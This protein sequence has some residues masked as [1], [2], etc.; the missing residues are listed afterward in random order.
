MAI[1]SVKTVQIG[2]QEA[3]KSLADLR[4]QITDCKNELFEL[5]EGSEEYNDKLQ[6]LGYAQQELTSFMQATRQGCTALEGSYNAL[7]YQLGLLKQ[8]WKSTNDEARRA[9][10]T[11]QI[12][13]I[14]DKL[15][16]MDASVGVFSRN[17]GNYTGSMVDAFNKVGINIGNINPLFANLA[18]GMVE[19]GAKGAKGLS[20]LSAGAKGLGAALKSLAANPI[21]AIIMAIVLAVKA[22]KA[23]FDAVK[24]SVARNEEA[25][26]N[27]AKAA[28]P[29]KAIIQGITNVF[30]EF[31]E[32][33]S[34]VAAGIGSA[35]SAIAKFFKGDSY[36]NSLVGKM[37]EIAELEDTI[38]E[39]HRNNMVENARL[40]MEA[41]EAREKA[42]NKEQY[43]NE[44]RLAFAKEYAE[45]QQEIAANNLKEAEDELKLL[46]LQASTGKNNAEMNDKLAAA[47]A[48][49]YQVQTAYN[50]ALRQTNKEIA[51]INKEIANE[52]T[53]AHK[54]AQAAAK[55]HAEE[56]KRL[57]AEYK[58]IVQ[59]LDEELSINEYEK[60]FLQI[61]KT[62]EDTTTKLKNELKK[63]AITQQQYNDAI[64]KADALQLAQTIELYQKK[65]D[66]LQQF[67]NDYKKL[68]MSDAAAKIAS[69]KEKW[70]KEFKAIEDA[71]KTQLISDKQ[72]EEMT[73][74]LAIKSEQ[75]IQ[76]VRNEAYLKA[77]QDRLK[78]ALD[79]EAIVAEAEENALKEEYLNREITTQEYIQREFDLR[80]E[81]NNKKIT[82]EEAYRDKLKDNLD[83][84]LID[85][86]TYNQAIAE[87][88]NILTELRLQNLELVKSKTEELNDVV[89]TGLVGVFDVM[90]EYVSTLDT[91]SSKWGDVFSN[92]SAMINGVGEALKSN[93]K[94]F[95]KWGQVAAMSCNMVSSMF[96]ALADE[97]DTNT[98]EGF[99]QSKK[100]RYGEA[101]MSMASAIIGAWS[102][103]MT[104][105]APASFIVGGIMSTLMTALGA[106]QVANIAKQNFDDTSTTAAK[107]ST[108][109]VSMSLQAPVQYATEVTPDSEIK[110]TDNIYVNVTEI[111]QV[112]Q[113]VNVAEQEATY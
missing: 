36:D 79:A 102:S 81:A 64:E 52:Q 3:V 51:S 69:E 47:Q 42:A 60:T 83:K 31:V 10:L 48:K 86:T 107:P 9:E 105:P 98:R 30:D 58:G 12:S 63:R 19:A 76:K 61:Q 46:E 22:L 32:I 54:K 94:G 66:A 68:Y 11:E 16:E 53:E 109:G 65:A 8:E 28:A 71:R 1:E 78:V 101:V 34:K 103:A 92:T 85:Q 25:Q 97:Q 88:D 57:K 26:K 56:I 44:Q 111:Q 77:A 49:V 91:I 113:R 4:K 6:E 82:L 15:K 17:V 73:K 33:L 104:L 62:Y 2:T 93:E 72:A 18:N 50:Q 21:G 20:A 87:S 38:Q 40:E 5:T 27:F 43:T 41:S 84:G 74:Q 96:G 45:K 37:N 70:N 24:D 14:N 90:S 99:E 35:M 75:E 39:N 100:L 55:S 95:K 106:V 89:V 112:G 29:I 59:K 13:S 110:E 7:S 80:I 108:G 23:G 67:N